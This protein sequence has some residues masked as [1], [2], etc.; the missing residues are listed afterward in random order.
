MLLPAESEQ[1]PLPYRWGYF[2]GIL[3]L[4]FSLLALLVTIEPSKATQSQS[5]YLSVAEC[6]GGIVAFPL[7]IGLLAKKRF[8]IPLVHLMFGLALLLA[9]LK[10]P[11]AIQH[12]TDLGDEGSAFFEAE[13]LLMRLLSL[14]YYR[15]RAHEF[16]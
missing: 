7:G 12:F 6:L 11:T 1:K 3:L 8:A 9:A 5:W 13:W 16:R 2:Q 14:F 15:K 10:V 4:P